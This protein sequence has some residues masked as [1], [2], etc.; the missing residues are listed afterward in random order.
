MSYDPR[1]RAS[2]PDAVANRQ[3][4][5]GIACRVLNQQLRDL[6]G[7]RPYNELVLPSGTY[8]LA[9]PGSAYVVYSATGGTVRLKVP[10]PPRE[11]EVTR[12]NP[13]TGVRRTLVPD[14][15]DDELVLPLPRG[16]D[17]VIVVS[18]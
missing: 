2:R 15:Q 18:L 7:M 1:V 8:C 10:T 9:R 14:R 11:W 4:W 3:R 13:R 12:I 6:R 17:W 5:L 16:T